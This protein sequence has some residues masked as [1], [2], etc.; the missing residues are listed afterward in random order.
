MAKENAVG[1]LSSS[2][3]Y[4]D[5]LTVIGSMAVLSNCAPLAHARAGRGIKTRV[6][7]GG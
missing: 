2:R 6:L 5:E 1:R 7:P 4:N 3:V